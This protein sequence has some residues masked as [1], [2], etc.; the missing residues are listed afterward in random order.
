MNG[1]MNVPHDWFWP[2][3]SRTAKRAPLRS[4]SRCMPSEP[5][6]RPPCARLLGAKETEEQAAAG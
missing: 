6:G 3:I 1:V 4:Q 2:V 5:M